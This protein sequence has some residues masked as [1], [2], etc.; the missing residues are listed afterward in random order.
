[1]RFKPHDY[2]RYCIS[3]MIKEPRLGLM[4]NMG[5]G[6]SAITL[7]AIN[8]LMFY[9][10]EIGKALIIAPKRVAE[11]TW[12]DECEKWDHLQ[13]LKISK[14]L[15][16]ESKRVEAV[17]ADADIYIV[18]RENVTW[19]VDRFKSKWKWDT[20]VIDELSSFKNHRSKRFKSLKK[21][22]P[23][24]KRLYGLTGTPAANGLMD[25]WAQVYLLDQGKRLYKTIGQYRERFFLP[26]KRN[27]QIVYSYK[28]KTDAEPTIRSLIS[29]ICVSVSPEDF[30]E[31]PDCV[32]QSQSLV[33]SN[34]SKKAY[35]EMEQKLVLELAETEITAVNAGVLTNK[36]LQ[37]ASG[38]VYDEN[39][40][41]HLIHK[42]K[43][44]ILNELIEQAASPVLVFY[45]YRHE[46]DTILKE[47][48]EARALDSDQ[49]IR[50][51]NT[52][53]V[54]ILLAHPAS[55]AYGLNMQQGGHTIV[56]F[57]PT[58]NLELYEQANARLNRQGQKETVT[59]NHIIAKGTVDEIVMKALKS[60][61]KTQEALLKALEKKLCFY[62]R[63]RK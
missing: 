10:H 44:E 3:R 63:D 9:R 52:G 31:L 41:Y 23:H 55:A 2:Q 51:W 15:G 57:S 1:M 48:K 20:V 58:W 29:D 43:L 7:T 8:E 4:L 17:N 32:Y 33:L 37:I 6:K 34:K 45:N 14:I 36:L 27:A 11:T 59:V 30:L 21:M 35:N 13:H 24:I 49:D 5:L 53:K 38:S 28:P 39:G 60:K 42:E 16:S 54:P 61:D 62:E 25:L 12:S 50:D 19:L 22:L 18:N 47:F 46:R 40:K 26:D 56:W